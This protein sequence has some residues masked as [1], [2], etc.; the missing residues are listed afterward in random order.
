M[1]LDIEDMR[2]F[3]CRLEDSSPS[4]TRPFNN[5]RKGLPLEPLSY[6]NR[7]SVLFANCALLMYGYG[8]SFVRYVVRGCLLIPFLRDDNMRFTVVSTRLG[9]H[10]LPDEFKDLTWVE[11]MLCSQYHNT[12][13]VTR[14]YDSSDP[15]QPRLFHGNTCAHDMS[16]I[17]IADTLPTT[18]AGIDGMLSVIL[19][20]SPRCC[21]QDH[22][23]NVKRLEIAK[24][25]APM[26]SV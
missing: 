7:I 3:G 22:E 23:S 20:L 9:L 24:M 2:G 5:P 10:V 8:R 21:A 26:I 18:P 16:V 1:P 13:H 19:M 12:T 17:S 11:E 4:S 14:L 6:S 25:N 15:A